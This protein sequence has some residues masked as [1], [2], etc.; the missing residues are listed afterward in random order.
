[1]CVFSITRGDA[2][3]KAYLLY[4]NKAQAVHQTRSQIFKLI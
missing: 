2:K 3:H 1:L 4:G